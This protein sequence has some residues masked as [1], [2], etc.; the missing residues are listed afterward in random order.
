[1]ANRDSHK[2]LIIACGAIAGEIVKLQRQLSFSKEAITLKCL[3]ADYHNTPQKIA[4]AIEKILEDCR[5]HYDV[6]LVGYGD[7]GTGGKLDA[8]LEKY[9][10]TRLPGAHC[11]EFFAGA[12][13]FE[14][15]IEEELGSF[16]VTDYLV[17][18]FDRL[19]IR[20]L[21][22]DRYPHLC[23]IYFANYKR[24]VYL[25]QEEDPVLIK[26]A[27]AAADALGLQFHYRKVGYGDLG[28]MMKS[29][30]LKSS[31]APDVSG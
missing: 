1:M 3:P 31:G 12:Q 25:A 9:D 22:L 21:G 15:M 20:G 17:K 23:E 7:C 28:Q 5:D 2:C 26:K 29:L 10:A 16:F 27:Q 13:L 18:F 8:V 11:Y 6:V 4:P 30:P 24:V 14:D 19:V